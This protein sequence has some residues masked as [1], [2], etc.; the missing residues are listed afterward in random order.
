MNQS[1]RSIRD[2]VASVALLAATRGVKVVVALDPELEKRASRELG[3]AVQGALEWVV[4]NASTRSLITLEQHEDEVILTIWGD[5][6]SGLALDPT[7]LSW[8]ES[9]VSKFRGS[10]SLSREVAG[11]QVS[12]TTPRSYWGIVHDPVQTL[13][14]RVGALETAVWAMCRGLPADTRAEIISALDHMREAMDSISARSA[15]PR[16]ADS[17]AEASHRFVKMLRKTP[18]GTKK[19]S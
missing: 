4:L 15:D 5:A 19:N 9:Q 7:K 14:G 11:V 13:A 2:V 3:E 1:R 17:Y 10:L 16:V 8:V 18:P 12:I 6:S